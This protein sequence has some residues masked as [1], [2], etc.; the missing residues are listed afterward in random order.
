MFHKNDKRYKLEE[1]EM[2]SYR[3]YP[4]S[5][6]GNAKRGIGLNEKG[7]NKCH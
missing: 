6:S 2:E 7:R 4:D 3:D 5:V 1:V